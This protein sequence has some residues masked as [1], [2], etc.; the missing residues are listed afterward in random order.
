MDTFMCR[1]E[2]LCLCVCAGRR[3]CCLV[4]A[5]ALHVNSEPQEG[6]DA[7]MLI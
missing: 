7:N 3:C 2:V 4:L 5:F 1:C 6:V